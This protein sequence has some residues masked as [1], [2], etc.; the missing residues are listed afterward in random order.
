MRRKALVVLTCIFL[1]SIGG[2]IM[3]HKA[4]AE[5][6]RVLFVWYIIDA[7]NP[8]PAL[9]LCTKSTLSTYT[10]NEADKAPGAPTIMQSILYSVAVNSSVCPAIRIW[11]AI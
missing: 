5:N 11:A 9:R 10:S 7:L 3:A 6:K 1:A 2:G 4:Q 8:N